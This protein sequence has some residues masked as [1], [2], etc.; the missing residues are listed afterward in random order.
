[1]ITSA[2]DQDNKANIIKHLELS[3]LEQLVHLK[4]RACGF[5]RDG[6]LHGLFQPWK[7]ISC[8]TDGVHGV[9]AKRVVP[10]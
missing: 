6:L 7:Y 10:V 9:P 5:R 3:L 8:H 2:P 4:L 1:M